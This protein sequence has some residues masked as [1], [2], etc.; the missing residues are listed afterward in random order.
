MRK[1]DMSQPSY[2][3]YIKS[4]DW[5]AKHT[6]WLKAVGYRCSMFPWVKIG[7]GRKYRIHHLHYR[8]LGS[9]RLRR[10][11]VP[12]CPFAHDFIIHGIL[13][14]FRSAGKQ[15]RYPNLAQRAVHLW[16]IQRLWMKGLL[17]L[18]LVAWLIAKFGSI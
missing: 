13:S 17:M 8:N 16:C 18:G 15:K 10:D 4:N 9:E 3:T 12:L 2:G 6:T 11:V 14:G 7:R 1:F 5:Y